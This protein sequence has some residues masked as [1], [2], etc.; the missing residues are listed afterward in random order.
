MCG[1][2]LIPAWVGAIRFTLSAERYRV[3]II[4]A[5]RIPASR[6]AP[7]LASVS[8]HAAAHPFPY[9]WEAKIFLERDIHQPIYDLYEC[10]SVDF[11]AKFDAI[12]CCRFDA[13]FKCGILRC[14]TLR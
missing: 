10:V 13:D 6:S 3:P 4:P 1:P 2:G 7:T 5:R 12:Q 9:C 14:V 8:L 11:V